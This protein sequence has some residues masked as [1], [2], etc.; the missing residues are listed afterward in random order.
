MK[1]DVCTFGHQF[2]WSTFKRSVVCWGKCWRNVSLLSQESVGGTRRNMDKAG[3][4][5]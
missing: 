4:V 1:S 2:I 3:G 5:A